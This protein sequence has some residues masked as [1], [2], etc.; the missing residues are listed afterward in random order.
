MSS[1]YIF[2]SHFRNS[3]TNPKQ[4]DAINGDSPNV[5]WKRACQNKYTTNDKIAA[6]K[7]LRPAHN[8]GLKEAKDVVEAYMDEYSVNGFD[9]AKVVT[10]IK[11]NNET[12]V[13]VTRKHEG[14]S[15]V[16]IIR[17]LSDSFSDS[18]VLQVVAKLAREYNGEGN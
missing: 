18:E 8:L 12:T 10:T 7:L 9:A 16:R 14:V 15:T 6:I 5:E 11:L 2:R 3:F 13:E 4:Y 1:R 17:T